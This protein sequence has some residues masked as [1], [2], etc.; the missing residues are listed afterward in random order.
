MR[1]NMKAARQME[2]EW[3]NE[4]MRINKERNEE[5]NKQTRKGNWF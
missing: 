4:Y 5:R 3:S 2:T 1:N